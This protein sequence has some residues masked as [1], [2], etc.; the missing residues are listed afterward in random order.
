VAGRA[1][2]KQANESP[3]RRSRK[4]RQV[5]YILSDLTGALIAVVRPLP[6]VMVDLPTWYTGGD[7]PYGVGIRKPGHAP[8]L[9]LHLNPGVLRASARVR[10][11][12]GNLVG[13]VRFG[14]S[15]RYSRRLRF[16]RNCTCERPPQ[17]CIC[18]TRQGRVRPISGS[19]A[20]W[21]VHDVSGQ[22]VAGITSRSFDSS[23]VTTPK[24]PLMVCEVIE[25][26]PDLDWNQHG[27]LV[28][29]AAMCDERVRT[30]MFLPWYQ[31]AV[32]GI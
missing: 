27:L 19:K 14:Y 9:L 16:K 32:R 22:Q 11:A 28:A 2:P 29:L 13:I 20:T 25:A 17:E 4:D 7:L 10:V 30:A 26:S 23:V 15:P 18:G 31:A 12:P 24:K 3:A 21:T 8:E 5:E 1:D 6:H